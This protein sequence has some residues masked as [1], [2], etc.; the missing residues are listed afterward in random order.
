MSEKIAEPK[1]S[2]RRFR[3]TSIES[4][5]PAGSR[6]RWSSTEQKEPVRRRAEE[7]TTSE[8]YANDLTIEFAW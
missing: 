2:D 3:A 5:F 4:G 1:S 8:S 6:Q 7:L